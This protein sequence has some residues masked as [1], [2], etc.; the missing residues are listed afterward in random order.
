MWAEFFADHY[1]AVP[2]LGVLLLMSGYF[3]GTETALFSLSPGQLYRLR[4]T[5]GRLER[6][7]GGMM[8]RPRRVL[9]VLLLGNMLVN[10][11]YA[12]DSAVLLQDL[13]HRG[14]PLVFLAASVVSVLGLILIGEVTPK[15]LAIRLGARWAV[16]AVGPLAVIQRALNPI[17]A[18]LDRLLVA[19]ATRV[20]APRT[21]EGAHVTA[22]ELYR[23]LEINARQGLIPRD[24]GEFL[25]EIIELT[26]LRVSDIMVPRVDMVTF[27]ID[28]PR[29]ELAELFRQTH[30]RKI[31]VYEQDVDHI[32]GVIHAKRMLLKPGAPL[33]SL[34]R[35]VVFVPDAGNL[36]KLLL[37]LRVR[38]AQMAIV[39]D[40]YGG[41]AG[42][43]TIEDVLEEI[44]G[45]IPD[46][47]GQ[48][49]DSPVVDRIGRDEYLID[50]DLGLHEWADAFHLDLASQRI[51]TI[52]GFLSA[53]L[54]RVP[55]VGD[56]VDYGNVRFTVR[57]MRRRRIGRIHV[58]L[59]E[60]QP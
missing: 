7:V 43:V 28:R 56:S 32:L 21:G 23:L 53:Q 22:E 26:D 3:S 12:S 27:D 42:L 36:E 59:T 41:T 10:V 60:K 4:H 50:A 40:E 33:R 2:S 49:P 17:V 11:A 38:R 48:Q 18:V 20:L 46:E 30:L 39:V 35:D 19:P 14:G 55:R 58:Q 8:N 1:L 52:G 31:P 44:V 16:A 5:G 54:G 51:S 24:A 6:M 47:T 37:Q 15:M 13:A 25:Q 34:V 57:S 9:N 45:D 29:S